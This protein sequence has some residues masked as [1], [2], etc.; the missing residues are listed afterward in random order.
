MRHKDLPGF[1]RSFSQRLLMMTLTSFVIAVSVTKNK[2]LLELFSHEIR[3]LCY[4][5]QHFLNAKASSANANSDSAGPGGRHDNDFVGYRETAIYPTSDEF[6]SVIQPFYRPAREVVEAEPD[7]WVGIHLDNQFRLLRED[8]LAELREDIEVV[9]GKKKG[10]R[11]N[12]IFKGLTLA[13]IECGD[14]QKWKPCALEFHC[15]VG[16]EKFERLSTPERKAFLKNNPRDLKHQSFGCLFQGGNFVVFAVL[17]RDEAGLLADPP[18]ITLQICGNEA[19]KYLL[20]A[21]KEQEAVDYIQGE[22]PFF[23]YEPVLQC[24]QEMKDLPL[25]RFLLG[26]QPDG[27]TQNSVA[28]DTSFIEKLVAQGASFIQQNLKMDKPINLDQSQTN[29]LVSGLKQPVSLIQGPPGEFSC[30]FD[31]TQL[32]TLARHGSLSRHPFEPCLGQSNP[33]TRAS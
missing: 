16:M 17:E 2:P 1:F 26:T 22:T 28:I 27:A 10:R 24:L 8:M 4:K 25:S 9:L 21:L 11:P 3:G 14:S 32:L 6:M 23:A 18:A 20:L 12:V 33:T 31:L 30:Y 29:A 7:T 15:G 13:G 19:I 5:I